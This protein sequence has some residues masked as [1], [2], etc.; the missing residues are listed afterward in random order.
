[1]NKASKIDN[2]SL[3]SLFMF[4]VQEYD[5]ITACVPLPTKIECSSISDPLGLRGSKI[6]DIEMVWTAI[7][8]RMMLQRKYFSNSERVQ[9][10]KLFDIA[11]TDPRFSAKAIG[12]LRK[13]LKQPLGRDIELLLQDGNDVQGHFSNIEDIVYGSL[14][15]ADY[16][17]AMRLQA[18]PNNVRMHALT[19]F[20][21]S[22]EQIIFKFRDLCISAEVPTLARIDGS[23]AAV[24]NLDASRGE[25]KEVSG[26]PY[27]SNIAGHD[28]DV[29][30]LVCIAEKLSDDDA[31]T[32]LIAK[33]FVGLLMEEPLDVERLDDVVWQDS[34]L[35]RDGFK[36]AAGL[37]RSI[38]DIG[39]SSHIAHEGGPNNAQVKLFPNVPNAWITNTPQLLTNVYQLHF[40]KRCGE[41]KVIAITEP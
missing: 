15:H 29:D 5:A 38:P 27:W 33:V 20:V 26:S 16:D 36:H 23:K 25:A 22:R 37:I 17:R 32:F 34:W 14:L 13:R 4:T 39:A 11:E 2:A 1:M 18:I 8:V 31:A 10:K 19:P 41:W 35:Y 21:F 40:E 24:L 9:L 6:E 30:E 3:L 12:D 28:A 7:C